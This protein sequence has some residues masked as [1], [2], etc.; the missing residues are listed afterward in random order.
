MAYYIPEQDP[1]RLAELTAHGPGPIHEMDGTYRP[2]TAPNGTEVLLWTS[3][4]RLTETLYTHVEDVLKRPR[5]H[6]YFPTN[7]DLTKPSFHAMIESTFHPSP[8]DYRLVE[9]HLW[10]H[11]HS[12]GELAK[13]IRLDAEIEVPGSALGELQADSTIA[14]CGDLHIEH[15]G[16]VFQMEAV[17]LDRT[18]LDNNVDS[19]VTAE[20][21][22]ALDHYTDALHRN[23][24]ERR[25]DTVS[26]GARPDQL[27]ASQTSEWTEQARIGEL[28]TWPGGA[29]TQKVVAELDHATAAWQRIL[30]EPWTILPHQSEHDLHEAQARRKLDFSTDMSRARVHEWAVAAKPATLTPDHPLPTMQLTEADLRRRAV[31]HAVD[32]GIRHEPP[33]P[34]P[35]AALTPQQHPQLRRIEPSPFHPVEHRRLSM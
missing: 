3:R 34:P 28:R 25:L 11:M 30:D 12:P 35:Q 22:A 14:S 32:R 16:A 1:Y 24:N 10:E 27:I 4:P 8:D 13:N 2:F 26:R 7:S 29:A 33:S 23:L 18:Y 15:I 19:G 9:G 31:Q 6:R 5:T 17:R 21:R 20:Q